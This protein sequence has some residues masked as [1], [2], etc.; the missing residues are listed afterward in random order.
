MDGWRR[1]E[2]KSER[3]IVREEYR[4]AERE[5]EMEAR[6]GKEGGTVKVRQ[7]ERGGAREKKWDEIILSNLNYWILRG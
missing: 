5:T 3:E 6:K 1:E 7:R 2:R 4:E